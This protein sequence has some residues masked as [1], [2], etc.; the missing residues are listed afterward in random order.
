MQI[1]PNCPEW[2]S[3]NLNILSRLE[4]AWWPKAIKTVNGK[5]QT[6]ILPIPSKQNFQRSLT[7][8]VI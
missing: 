6:K 3:L 8:I 2:V 5:R 4:L 7:G 1:A